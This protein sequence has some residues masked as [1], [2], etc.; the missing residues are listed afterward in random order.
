MDAYPFLQIGRGWYPIWLLSLKRV[1]SEPPTIVQGSSFFGGG[2]VPFNFEIPSLKLT[3]SPL[4]NGW[5]WKTIRLPFRPIFR[6]ILVSFRGEVSIPSKFHVSKWVFPKIRVPPNYE[7]VHRVFHYK[8]SI[9]GYP[10]FWK[11][12]SYHLSREVFPPKKK[13]FRFQDLGR[14]KKKNKGS[15][16]APCPKNRPIQSGGYQLLPSDLLIPQ[17][18][19]T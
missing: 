13:F 17:M 14:P 15:I 5:D 16:W 9:V 6:W 7:F 12:P 2:Q 18:E 3:S 11:H 10:Y 1:G 8:P 4:K 19:V